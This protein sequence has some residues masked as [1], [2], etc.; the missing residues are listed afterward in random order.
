M[1]FSNLSIYL[2]G[3]DSNCK[4]EVTNC[5]KSL[6]G[7]VSSILGYKTTHVVST[8]EKVAENAYSIKKATEMKIPV[9]SQEW[10]LHS[11]DAKSKKKEDR[12][13]LNGGGSMEASSSH[14]GSV[15]LLPA[16]KQL[17]PESAKQSNL[18]IAIIGSNFTVSGVNMSVKIGSVEIVGDDICVYSSTVLIVRVPDHPK[19][20]IGN[21]LVQVSSDGGKNYG[22]GIEFKFTS[23][24]SKDLSSSGGFSHDFQLD[25]ES[26]EIRIFISSPFRDMQAERDWIVKWTIPKLRKI[27]S[28]RDVVLSYVDLRWGV[29]D[30]QSAKATTLLM[31]LR[32]LYR[33]NVFVGSF[34]ERYGWSHSNKPMQEENNALLQRTFDLAEKEF[35]WISKYRDRSITEVEMRG[36]LDKVIRMP[37]YFYFRDPKFIDTIKPYDRPKYQSEGTEEKSKLD[38]LKS[39]IKKYNTSSSLCVDYSDPKDMGKF[40]FDH[41]SQLIDKL[42]PAGSVPTEAEGES[43]T[44]EAYTRSLAR[45]YLPNQKYY[46]TIDKH[47]AY[48]NVPLIV[49]GDPGLGKSALLAN[50]A[51]RFKEHHPEDLVITHFV[52]CSAASTNYVNM[53]TRILEA[54]RE[55]VGKN[56]VSDLTISK[57]AN[58]LVQDFGIW[59]EKGSTVAGGRRIVLVIDGIDK[60][61]DCDNALDLLWLPRQFPDGVKVILSTLPGRPLEAIKNRSHEILE[62]VTLPEWE[63]VSFIRTYLNW[64]SKK[65]SELQEFKMA[66]NKQFEN[67]LYSKVFLDDIS[68]MGE[69][70]QLDQQI[71]TN[72]K[73]KDA[74]SLYEVVIRRLQR[75]YDN[76]NTGVVESFLTLLWAARRG[77]T[78]TEIEE[79][80]NG[81][82]HPPETWMPIFLA[83]EGMLF[84]CS[85]LLN[86]SDKVFKDA[87]KNVYLVN[88]KKITFSHEAIV[89]YFAIQQGY[90]HRKVEELPWQI[91]Q[92]NDPKRLSECLSDLDLF[93]KLYEHSE[94]KFHLIKWWTDLEKKNFDAV[95]TYNLAL[96]FYEKDKYYQ[97]G[98]ESISFLPFYSVG[99]FLEDLP[100]LEGSEQV[101]N[102]ALNHAQTP[103]DKTMVMNALARL[104]ETQA[105]YDLAESVLREAQSVNEK[106]YGKN[107]L[108]T[109]N[110]LTR[111]GA[112]LVHN[113]KLDEA[114]DALKLS[115]K[116][117]EEGLGKNHSRVG[118]TL[119]HLSTVC[120]MKGD[121]RAAEEHALRALKVTEESCGP[122]DF[123]VSSILLKIGVLYSELHRTKESEN[124]FKRALEIRKVKFGP[125]HPFT[126][127]VLREIAV[128][129]EQ[130]GKL[131]EAEEDYIQSLAIKKKS[132]GGL[133]PDIAQIQN[134]LAAVYTLQKRYDEAAKLLESALTIREAC[135]GPNH[136]RVGQTLKH[137][138]TLYEK[139]GNYQKAADCGYRALS[140]TR[141]AF[142]HDHFHVSSILLRLG[143]LEISLKKYDQ[144]QKSFEEALNI[145]KSKF[146]ELH[147]YVADVLHEIGH[148]MVKINKTQEAEFA[149]K[150]ALKIREKN[151]GMESNATKESKAAL[152]SIGVL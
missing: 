114:D 133:H 29:T 97:T 41:I 117:R 78:E 40:L 17:V 98:K 23:S 84:N 124:C 11:F 68:V 52:G 9:V 21:A 130:Q 43:A 48:S 20:P 31:C 7:Q 92:L 152:K 46:Y 62:L 6:G 32:E 116:I 111:L 67:P 49:I 95:K 86:F 28:E 61:D 50:W 103:Q 107:H 113:G 151:L 8:L 110:T 34:G 109:S 150:Q 42:F 134:R 105:R 53:L 127:D 80:M 94:H 70:D 129:Y 72:L 137:M 4:K 58:Q 90:G 138:L 74:C 38:K 121:Y 141:N 65:L 36:I 139:M 100:K 145:R 22:T 1:A 76:E 122:F 102:R 64:H 27:C 63:R 16:V 81:L 136:S 99:N 59:L 79:L 66:S 14:G 93:L 83:M 119:K 144:A 132:L 55:R 26:R 96:D 104:Y 118:Q 142:G 30:V 51:L 57:S 19:I 60:L 148:L 140:N 128:V 147:S 15:G 143:I 149:W 101:Y 73:A 91:A 44:H 2:Y 120:Q 56:N 106:I 25:P 45:V 135:L 13:I 5:I 88:Q 87:V 108:Q 126:A 112:V 115:L 33:C 125:D 54:I 69:F 39:D 18:E 82:N 71:D 35:P 24:Q 3:L 37:S 85:G 123:H 75:D 131:K 47:V 146:G 89:N 77:L 12:Y 10:V